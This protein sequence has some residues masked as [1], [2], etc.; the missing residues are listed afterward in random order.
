MNISRWILNKL[1]WKIN[2]TVDIEPKSILCVAPHTSNWD[3]IYGKLFAWAINLKTG[4]FMKKSLFIFPLGLVF[5]KMGGIPINRSKKT[6]VT[7]Q[8]I[9]Y[10]NAQKEFHLAITPEGTRK[11][12]IKWKKGFYFIAKGADIPIQLAYIDFEKKEIGITETFYPTDDIR[13]D[14]EHIYNYYRGKKG[15]IPENF[16]IPNVEDDESLK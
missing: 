5:R 4:F 6:S 9:D 8:T 3:F 10:A 1:G 14:F 15:C 2:V 11:A 13:A 7:Q 12:N 16:V